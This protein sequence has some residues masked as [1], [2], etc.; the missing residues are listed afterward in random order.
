MHQWE[1][2]ESM[3]GMHTEAAGEAAAVQQAGRDARLEA[4]QNAH[5]AVLVHVAVDARRPAK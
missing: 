1:V 5:A 3:E 2:R 4:R